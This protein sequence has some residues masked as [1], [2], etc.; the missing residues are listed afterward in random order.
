MVEQQLMEYDENGFTGTQWYSLHDW[1]LNSLARFFKVSKK[2][3]EIRLSE[4]GYCLH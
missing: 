1:A 2:P 3:V 4:T